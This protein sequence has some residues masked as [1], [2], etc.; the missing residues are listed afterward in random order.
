MN[1]VVLSCTLRNLKSVG[2]E[3]NSFYD[4]VRSKPFVCQGLIV[5]TLNL[6]ISSIDQNQIVNVALPSFVNMKG[7]SFIVNSLEDIVDMLVHYSDSVKPFIH[8]RRGEFVVVVKLYGA[9][10][11]AIEAYIGGEVVGSGGCGI[12]GKFC[13]K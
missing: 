1:D 2:I 7:A 10:I 5:S 8:V 3:A 4:L 12:V 9:W 11:K 6:E 13:E